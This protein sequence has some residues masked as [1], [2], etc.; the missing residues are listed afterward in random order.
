MTKTLQVSLAVLLTAAAVAADGAS[1]QRVVQI[2]MYN[3]SRLQPCDVDEMVAIANRVWAPYNVRLEA[4]TGPDAITVVLSDRP[5]GRPDAGGEVLG[6]TLFTN[7]H[8]TPY[9]NLSPAAAE[10]FARGARDEGLAFDVRPGAQRKDVLVRILGVAFAHEIAH[11]LL[12]TAR[13][14]SVGLLQAGLGIRELT[15]KAPGHLTLTRDQER[16]LRGDAAPERQ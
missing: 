15:L 6:T 4:G 12:D 9:I 16:L 2:R 14:S 7:G 1:P 13:H 8:A 11:Y 3:R 5:L 10:T